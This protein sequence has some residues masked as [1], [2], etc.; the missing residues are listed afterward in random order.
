MRP[1]ETGCPETA[2]DKSILAKRKAQ[3]LA[4]EGHVRQACEEMRRLLG[5][6]EVDP[7]DHVYLGDLLLR[8]GESE[9]AL[10]SWESAVASYEKVG[11]YRNAIA[12]C[13]KILRLDARRVRVHRSL[14]DL[15]HREGL[16]TEALTHLLVYL[17]AFRDVHALP[18]GYADT[19]DQAAGICAANQIEPT[20]RLADH[21]ARIGREDRSAELL[22]NLAEC[23]A[24]TGTDDLEAE[25]RDRVRAAQAGFLA[26]QSAEGAPVP[27][28]PP[29]ALTVE[30]SAE[31]P[32]AEPSQVEDVPAPGAPVVTE[33]VL[34]SGVG[35][36]DGFEEESVPSP[37][38]TEPEEFSGFE[39][40]PTPSRDPVTEGIPPADA[41]EEIEP[42]STEETDAGGPGFHSLLAHA[43]AAEA[44]GSWAE[45]RGIC[46]QL[47]HER[48]LDPTLLERLVR[49]SRGMAD[50]TAEI[51]YLV[52]LGD[53]WI[54]EGELPKALPI[55]LQV[56]RCDRG[57]PTARRRLARFREMGLPG[58]ESVSD[59][60]DEEADSM[61]GVL[62]TSG[63]HVSIGSDA[64]RS[65]EWVDLGALLEEFR[66]GVKNQIDGDDFQ[67][68]YDLAVS[69]QAM[70]LYEEA[71]E[72]AEMVVGHSQ[73][74]LEMELSVRE[75]RGNCLM[76]MERH[77]EA[78]HEFR[79]ALEKAGDEPVR[80][81]SILYHL[82]LA[83][84]SAGE[85]R[86]AAEAFETILNGSPGYLD[87]PE[88]L[89]TC[90][91]NGGGGDTSAEGESR[92]A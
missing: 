79:T 92:A 63:A 23:V 12:I 86:E 44:A 78:V 76:Q 14:G 17:D 59:G 70:G 89:R 3:K 8:L 83:L 85:W 9:E 5:E 71:L 51:H 91:D 56:Q 67:S 34:S 74:P 75:L 57:N 6:N 64:I 37:A 26:R 31:P 80:R 88:R 21:Y 36:S 4:R 1:G 52:L 10:S 45:A 55:F 28:D 25:L 15:F 53:A 7:Y 48:P 16:I 33:A 60:A 35:W 46:E 19:L 72:Q 69:D 87:A 20:L 11:L 40:F 82:G 27:I 73:V 58:T 42:I 81:W 22:Q 49:A 30:F 24:E 50:A 65:D 66:Q 62:E 84:Q 61:R 43:D 68:H 41:E 13:K 38:R 2:L 77:R 32:E 29:G 90:R 54:E 18:N 47:L 39:H